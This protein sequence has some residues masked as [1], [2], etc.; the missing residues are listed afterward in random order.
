MRYTRK[1]GFLGFLLIVY[2]TGQQVV[3]PGGAS[4]HA[5]VALA[6]QLPKACKQEDIETY[7]RPVLFSRRG[8]L[9]FGVS[10]PRDHYE[11]GEQ[12][13]IHIWLSNEFN[14]KQEF[15]ICCENTF[16]EHIKVLDESGN[17]L[18]SVPEIAVR[19]AH[20]KGLESVQV[21]S[22]SGFSVVAAGSCRV[23]DGGTL[24]RHDTAYDLAPGEYSVEEREP[25]PGSD[26]SKS[27]LPPND[28][29]TAVGLVIR[30]DGQ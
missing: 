18:E 29:S 13:H 28:Q 17:R 12:I 9:T 15:Y 24:N 23:I 16:L 20:E 22:C 4:S 11:K 25:K 30:I 8:G 7:G 26:P 21:C 14:D 10:S 5:D 19:K 2:A 3:R 27:L 1:C 6:A